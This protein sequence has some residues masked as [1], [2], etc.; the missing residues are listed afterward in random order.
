MS[1]PFGQTVKGVRVPNIKGTSIVPL[2]ASIINKGMVTSVDP[3]DIDNATLQL[4]RNAIVR[5]DKTSRR[6]ATNLITPVKPDSNSVIKVQTFKQNDGTQQTFR[7]TPTTIH[8]RDVAWTALAITPLVGTINDRITTAVVDNKLFIANNGKNVPLIVNSLGTL[9]TEIVNPGFAYAPPKYRYIT[10]FFNRLVGAAVRDT[11]EI[12][13][14]WSGDKNTTEFDAT[15]DTSAGFG[16]LVD[17]SDDTTDFIK[18]I[19]GLTNFMV[20]FREKSLWLASKQPIPTNPFYFF[21]AVP[22]IGCDAPFS[23]QVIHG[24]VAWLDTR[25]GCVYT[26]SA[27]P[28]TMPEAIGRGVENKIMDGISSP[29]IIFS[30]YDST[31][32]EYHI[33][34]PSVG[35][36]Y[37]KVWTYNLKTQAWTQNEYYGLTSLDSTTAASAYT[38]I[39]DLGDV[40]IDDLVGMIDDLGPIQPN[41]PTKL[42]GRSDGSITQESLTSELDAAYA[43]DFPNGIPITS[44]YISKVFELD[45]TKVTVSKLVIDYKALRGG[46]FTLSYSRNGGET[47][48]VGKTAVFTLNDKVR[49]KVII[50]RPI[51]ATSFVWKLTITTGDLAILGYEIQ[52]SRA[53]SAVENK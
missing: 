15:V 47:W 53:E 5:L 7:F 29:D 1:K 44:E 2:A 8:K 46:S 26:W 37:V 22:G 10:G 27:Q 23:Q 43:V 40:F 25:T 50:K 9:A 51:K 41:K 14:G 38:T 16:P 32:M 34:I 6:A 19:F 20:I 45:S 52:I 3:A 12:Q 24:G 13:I 49:K 18:G 48:I 21:S 30:S 36:N 42:F 17:S 31:E 35:S 33:G 11:N 4:A 39:D 28:N